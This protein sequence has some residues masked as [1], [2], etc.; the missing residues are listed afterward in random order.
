MKLSEILAKKKPGG[1][2]ITPETERAQIAKTIKL[3]LDATAPKI[4]PPAMMPE[5]RELGAMVPGERIP[6]QHAPEGTQEA[7]WISAA[8]CFET[9]L[10]IVLEPNPSP[11]AWLA[12]TR[13]KSSPILLHRLPLENLTN[14]NNP[15]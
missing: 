2:K 6:M 5:P 9:N 10:C 8:H 11:F 4:T 7:A 3:T 12:V 13:P 15:F 1:I 14:A